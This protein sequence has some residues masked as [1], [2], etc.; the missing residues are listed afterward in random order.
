MKKYLYIKKKKKTSINNSKEKNNLPS[1]KNIKSNRLDS[2][3]PN[4][5]ELENNKIN[6]RK[7]EERGKINKYIIYLVPK[8]SKIKILK[9]K[10][11]EIKKSN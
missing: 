6:K 9:T 11:K 2:F 1:N 8:D 5:P 10:K 7:R 3:S 4:R